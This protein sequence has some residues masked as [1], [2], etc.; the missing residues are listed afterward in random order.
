[1]N[2]VAIESKY[3][4][5][6][7]KLTR[8]TYE[9]IEDVIQYLEDNKIRFEDTSYSN[10]IIKIYNNKGQSYGYTYTTGRWCCYKKGKLIKHY[11]S[12][13]IEDFVINYLNKY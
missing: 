11:H 12:K 13:G 5:S 8:K 2:N 10:S 6:K 9:K 7:G 4:W 3:R 1:M